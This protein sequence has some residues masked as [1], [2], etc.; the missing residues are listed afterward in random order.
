VQR[1]EGQ[2]WLRSLTVVPAML[3]QKYPCSAGGRS[4]EG[5]YMNV[6]HHADRWE[7]LRRGM[8]APA[9]LSLPSGRMHLCKLCACAGHGLAQLLCT[10]PELDIGRQL[11]LDEVGT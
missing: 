4:L 8:G 3:A 2:I 6:S 7:S 5:G 9:Q 1:S 10:W 11:F